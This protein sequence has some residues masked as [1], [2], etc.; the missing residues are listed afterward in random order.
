M[1]QSVNLKQIIDT[2]LAQTSEESSMLLGQQLGV[3]ESDN[4]N[5]NKVTYFADMDDAIFVAS[6]ETREEYPGQFYMIFSLRDAILL[7]GLLL[8]IPLQRISEKRKL[9][10]ME[11]DDVDAFGEIMNQVIGSF[12]SVFKASLPEKIHLKLNVP[13]KFV[14]GIDEMSDEEPI[15]ADEYVLFRSQLTMDG[16]EMDRLDLLMPLSLANLIEPPA[17]APEQAQVVTPDSAV[18]GTAAQAEVAVV[19]G[20]NTILLLEDDEK[21]REHLKSCLCAAGMKVI[22]APLKADLRDLVA[23]NDTKVAVIGVADTE[24]RELALCIK[25]NA[26]RQD[27]SLP[28]I[29]CAPQWTRN[30][31]LKALKY[32]A[33]DIMLKPYDADELVT[34]VTRFLNAA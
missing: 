25:I 13:K 6:I 11:A 18:E 3:G 4:V 26:M 8:G 32:G 34:K 31:V 19:A 24:D 9:A 33:K 14:P 17:P 10:I 21:I 2:S 30:G 29:M 28:I 5:T 23:L 27:E 15:P 12:N 1:A 20:I 16:V 7:S 22:D